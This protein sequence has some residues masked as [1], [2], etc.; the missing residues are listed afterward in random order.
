MADSA[1]KPSCLL[2][3]ASTAEC[4]MCLVTG[5]IQFICSWNPFFFTSISSP[6]TCIGNFRGQYE[7]CWQEKLKMFYAEIIF[8]INV[9]QKNGIKSNTKWIGSWFF[10]WLPKQVFPPVSYFVEKDSVTIL[11]EKPKLSKSQH[12]V[13][14]LNSSSEHH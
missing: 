7:W 14:P 9:K 6:R 12:Q 3:T 11:Y 5:K 8:M 2:V 1:E 4:K 13:F 10:L